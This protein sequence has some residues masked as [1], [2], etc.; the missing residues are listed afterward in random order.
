KVAAILADLEAWHRRHGRPEA[1]FEARRTRLEQLRAALDQ[2]ADRQALEVELERA[3]EELGRRFAWWSLG[4]ATL[5]EWQRQGEEPEALVRARETAHAG[6]RAHPDSVGGRRSRHLVA[7]IEAPAFQL[8]TMTADGAGER[9]LRVTHRNLPTLWLRAYAV[10]LVRYLESAEDYQL[11]PAWR[12]VPEILRQQR[13]AAEWKVELPATPDFRD[14]HT[15]VTPPMEQPGLYVVVASA[16]PDFAR[17]HNQ[18][19]AVNLLLTDLVLLSRQQGETLAVRALSGASGEPRRGAHVDLYRFD[20]Q[21]GHRRAVT[22]TAGEDGRATLAIPEGRGHFLL[23][24]DGEHLALDLTHLRA[25][26]TSRA[27]RRA[28]LV[29]TDRSIYRP[30]QE[31]LWKVVAY[32]DDGSGTRFTTLPGVALRVELVD[33]DGEVAAARDVAANDHGTASGAF[34]IPRG[35]LLGGW[36]LRSSLGGAAAVRVEEYKRPTFEVT[37]DEPEGALRL[38]R[39]ATLAGE[40]RYYFGLPVATGDVTWRVTREPVYPWW[41]SWWGWAPPAPAQTVAAGTAALDADGRFRVTFTP[42][43]DERQAATG[44]SYR[45][46]LAV[47]VTDEGGETRAA[48]RAFRLGY[49]TVEARIEGEPVFARAGEPLAVAVHRAD[50]DGTP[51][52]GAGRWR[53]VR[54]V[55]PQ[56]T[57]LPADQP[58]PPPPGDGGEAYRTAGDLL[59]PRWDPGYDPAAVMRLW[60]AG[61]TVA[62][63]SLVHGDDGAAELTLP[64]LAA[65]AYRLLYA[66][67]DRFGATFETQRELVVAAAGAGLALP[68]LLLAESSTVAVGGTAR[69]LVASGL[70]SQSLLLE[71]HRRGEPVERYPLR[72]DGGMQLLEIPVARDD[73]GGFGVTLTL[74]RDH[75]LVQLRERVFVPWTDRQ[76]EVELVTFRDRLRPGEVERWR[77]RVSGA[78]GETLERGAAELLAYMYDRSLDLFAPHRPPE[79][80]ALYPDL[81]AVSPLRPT[82]GWGHPVWQESHQWARLPD[83]P[84]LRGDS[85]RHIS[86]YGIGGPGRRGRFAIRDMAAVGESLPAPPPAPAQMESVEELQVTAESPRLDER[87]GSADG[88]ERDGAP[89][90]DAPAPRT[91]FSETAF[92][93]PHLLLD[94]D[95]GVAFELTVPDSLT[96]WNVWLHAVTR[97]LRGGSAQA[98]ARSAKELMVRPYLPRFLREGDRAVLRVVVDN[99]SEE[100]LSGTLRLELFDPESGASRGADFGLGAA[101]PE[102]PFTVEPGRG[103][104]LSFPLEVPA[105]VGEVGFRVSATAGG[106]GDGEQRAIPVLPGRMHLAQSRFAALQEADRETLRFADLAAADDPTLIHDQL[107]VTIDGQLFYGVLSALPYLVEYPYECTEQTLNRFVSTGIVSSVFADHPAVAAMARQLAERDTRLE[108]WVADDPNR[109]MAL[110]ETPWLAASRGGGGEELLRMLD[111]QV[112]RAQREASLARLRQAQ[113]SLGAFPWF[114]GGPPSPYITLYVLHGLSK[115]LE[116]GVAVPREMVVSAWGYMHRYYVDELVRHAIATDCCWEMVTFLGYVLSA[117][118]DESW[119][120]GVFTAEQRR[121]MLDFSFRHWRQHSPLLKAQL[122]LSLTRVDRG[123]DALLVFDS[124]MDSSRTTDE[125]GT[126]WAAEDRAWLWYNDTVEGH[127]FAL[128]ALTELAPDDPRRHGLVQWLFLNKKLNHWKST[129]TT[130]EAIYA[131]VYFLEREGALG[132]R[133]EALVTVG[134]LRRSFVFEPDRYSGRNQQLVVPGEE[135]GPSM[136]TIE[137]SKETPGMLFASATWHFSTERLPAEARG[138]LLAVTRRYFR[139]V[140]DGREWTLVPLR[141]GTPLAVGDQVE[142]QLSLRAQHAAEYVHLRD[143]RGAGFEPE[144]LRSRHKWDLGVGWYEEVRDSGTNFFFESLP[145]G[146]YTFRYRLRAAMAGRFRV[147][148]ATL[149]S[150]YAPE[151]TAYS[152]GAELAVEAGAELAVE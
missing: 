99:A 2:P 117:Y 81:T 77:V 124:L 151:F 74:L 85:L 136:A 125:L 49:V 9:S 23:G 95:G 130:A 28:A 7:A 14:H 4:L 104:T 108:P 146:E 145:A 84:H 29:Y 61:E 78:E 86:G 127:A 83:Y 82:L 115:A 101:F 87:R 71:V 92:W 8:Q 26:P 53:L 34:T 18:R 134:P 114:P 50:L 135:V 133:E 121:Q 98:R 43:A 25:H 128:R 36:Q 126:F 76:L 17:R 33:P 150:M 5:A 67:E 102:V 118:P 152:A 22:A 65:G 103:T 100:P 30:G 47:E 140:H 68:A 38:N 48:E 73:R 97:D 56:E 122:A 20:W 142:V 51:R 129:R 46:R 60:P 32:E 80:L 41:W 93:Y 132:V 144:T 37:L 75:Q 141:E 15:Y 6:A 52:Q 70:P 105:G 89:P 45:F 64:P 58:L 106:L 13:P 147:A 66:T 131:L 88:S 31:L 107:V 123:D 120:G 116:H 55:Q 3:L 119:T 79:V 138:D 40:A 109:Q 112:A 59:R 96:E 94:D 39:A 16:R 44:V 110:E 63:G 1:A 113:T 12:E 57:P 10:D 72:A 54:L 11:L 91:D 62:S 19:A 90:G 137:V 35:R 149:Q 24:R 143:P 148:P 69:L 111:P 27:A 139:R 42:E 21:G